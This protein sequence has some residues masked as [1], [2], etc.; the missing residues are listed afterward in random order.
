MPDRLQG[1]DV[2]GKDAL[3][4]RSLLLLA[5]AALLHQGCHGARHP[6]I[7]APGEGLMRV[8][9]DNRLSMTLRGIGSF[10]ADCGSEA[11]G[12]DVECQPLRGIFGWG[13][14]IRTR[15][16]GVRVRSP[17]ARRSPSRGAGRRAI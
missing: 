1:L 16:D 15:V 8:V 17:T 3:G 12:E 4:Q 13:T 11:R 2:R 14:W 9:S 10:P 5:E 7:V 6:R